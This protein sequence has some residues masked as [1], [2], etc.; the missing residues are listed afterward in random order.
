MGNVFDF[1]DDISYDT[2]KQYASIEGAKQGFIRE[3]SFNIIW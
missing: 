1:D 3:Y 2:R